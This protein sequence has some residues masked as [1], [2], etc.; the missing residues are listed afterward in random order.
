MPFAIDIRGLSK[1]YK[2]YPN[3]R[4]RLLE[5]LSFGQTIRHTDFWALRDFNLQV[6]PGEC[7][8]I[9][10]PNGAG[11]STLLKLL[12]QTLSPT[13]GSF[14]IQGKVLSL[15]ELGTGFNAELTG[16]QNVI[17]TASLL[18][19]PEGYVRERMDDIAAFSNLGDFLDRP[20]KTYSSGMTV[21]LAFSMFVFLKPDVFI[22]DEALAVGDI[23]FQ[24]ACYKK[25]EEMLANGVTCLMVTHDLNAVVQFC[26]RAVM[27]VEGQKVFEGI[28]REAINRLNNLFFGLATELP[29]EETLGDGSADITEIWFENSFGDRIDSAATHQPVAFCLVVKFNTDVAEIDFGF[30]IKTLHGVE[31]TAVGSEK[32]GYRFGPFYRTQ[33]VTVR[34]NLDLNLNPGSYFFG[35]GVRYHGTNTFLARRV[36]AMRF[37]ISDLAVAGGII[38]PMREITVET[39]VMETAIR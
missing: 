30:H 20:L 37:P 7:V 13:S 28:P 38:N 21:R 10:G 9:V 3:P 4:A 26:D 15:L 11:K 2:I 6:R 16:R 8:G 39:A 18:G 31:V 14:S 33:I 25:I 22:I 35:G 1:R 19:F 12:S 5:W 24:R 23:G 36:D 17:E 32:I 29:P 34:W 27:L